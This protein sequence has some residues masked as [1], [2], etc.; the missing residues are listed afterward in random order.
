MEQL[1]IQCQ[2]A[3]LICKTLMSTELQDASSCESGSAEKAPWLESTLNLSGC[4]LD[5]PRMSQET[6]TLY[7]TAEMASVKPNHGDTPE[8]PAA[9]T[10]ELQGK[11]KRSR[12]S[13]TL[14][15]SS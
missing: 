8:P 1:L 13:N 11:Q 12:K 3:T 7:H 10:S 14:K 4:H 5:S 15:T 2:A 9:S 6:E